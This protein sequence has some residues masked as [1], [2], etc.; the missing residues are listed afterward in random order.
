MWSSAGDVI[1][2]L[3]SE[4]LTTAVVALSFVVA[5]G[6][7]VT[8]SQ[9]L[10]FHRRVNAWRVQVRIH[11]FLDVLKYLAAY[12]RDPVFIVHRYFRILH[13]ENLS[14]VA[15]FKETSVSFFFLRTITY[16]DSLLQRRQHMPFPLRPIL[17]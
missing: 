3:I 14:P 15:R 17:L 16:S 4:A 11:L 6:L 1:A 5:S 8:E 10:L 2:D 7:P 13:R 12:S 9:H